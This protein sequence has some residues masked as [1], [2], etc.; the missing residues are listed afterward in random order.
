MTTPPPAPPKGSCIRIEDGPTL[1]TYH[2]LPRKWWRTPAL[3]ATVQAVD[4][5]GQRVTLTRAAT[6]GVFA[7]AAKKRSGTIDVVI[8]TPS[9]ETHI[10]KVH[11]SVAEATLTWAV[12]FNA[13]RD[14]TR[15]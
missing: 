1:A 12:A 7:L 6:L 10:H 13:W 9:G 3:G 15:S 11:H 14:A 8:A 4:N 5:T 2:G